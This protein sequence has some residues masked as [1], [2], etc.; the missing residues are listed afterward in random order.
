F[1][2]DADAERLYRAAV[3]RLEQRGARIVS[4]D[5]TPFR[6]AARPLYQGPWV[7]ERLAAIRDFAD[8]KPEALHDVVG[9]II[10]G[11]A[12]LSAVEAFE[13]FYRLA[14]LTRAAEAQWQAMDAMLLPTTGTT[15]KISQV[16]ADP[17]QLNS[18]LGTYTNFVN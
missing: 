9:E 10:R 5:F 15:Y 12:L 7:A 2:G 6:E 17:I 3:G 4:I 18:N 8:R 1:F 14:E 11:A 16:L 13:G